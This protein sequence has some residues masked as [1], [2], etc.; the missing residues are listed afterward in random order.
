[1]VDQGLGVADIGQMGEEVKRFNQGP[2]RL[3]ATGHGE[4]EH[5]PGALGQQFQGQRMIRMVRQ[6]RVAD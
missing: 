3:P 4:A 6:P 1:M 5:C 2:A